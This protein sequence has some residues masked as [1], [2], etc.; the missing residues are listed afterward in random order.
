MKIPKIEYD[1]YCKLYGTN[2]IKLNLTVCENNKIDLFVPVKI[3]EDI[4]K[5]NGKSGYYNDIC[6]TTSDNDFD[7][8]L[9]DRKNEFMEGNKTI[10][11]EDCEFSKYDYINEK[12]ICSCKPKK[13]AASF[14]DMQI[15]K[16]KLLENFIDIQ[17]IVNTKLMICYKELFSKS[18]IK[19][20]IA[21]YIIIPIIIFHLISIFIFYK[22]QKL[23][24]D[25]IIKDIS[26]AINNWDLVKEYEKE[27]KR[28]EKNENNNVSSK[29][30]DKN[31]IKI[32]PQSNQLTEVGDI[33][34]PIKKRK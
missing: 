16:T 30:E 24:I 12:A 29:N 21:F 17:N 27:K 23:K 33:N 11:Q 28:L 34:K 10:C 20:N 8:S 18:G 2:L 19:T 6:Y 13:S 4:D 32:I 1:I 26:F 3:T 22:S 31:K 14:M 9:D 15:N 7:I 5:L 25:N